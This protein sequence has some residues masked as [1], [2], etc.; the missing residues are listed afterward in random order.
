MKCKNERHP[1]V[2]LYGEQPMLYHLI[3][4]LI[5]SKINCLVNTVTNS[6]VDLI[7]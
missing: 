1:Q 2:I 7:Q 6:R 4:H 3:M 5:F